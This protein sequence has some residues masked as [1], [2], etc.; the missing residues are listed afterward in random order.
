MEKSPY[1]FSYKDRP[2]W[3]EPEAGD[4]QQY[5]VQLKNFRRNM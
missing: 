5:R 3:H 1:N 2:P 4:V